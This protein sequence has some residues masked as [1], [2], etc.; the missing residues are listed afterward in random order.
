MNPNDINA[1]YNRGLS[2]GN[3]GDYQG[4]IDDF[5][6]IIKL[7]PNEVEVYQYKA[8]VQVGLD[9]SKGFQSKGKN[10]TKTRRV[11]IGRPG[12]RVNHKH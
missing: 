11:E 1:Y 4:A 8:M 6:Q 9:K 2:R 10:N 3:I 12:S 5:N 7:N